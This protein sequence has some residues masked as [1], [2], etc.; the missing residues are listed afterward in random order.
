MINNISQ[1]ITVFLSTTALV[2]SLIMTALPASAKEKGGHQ[3]MVVDGRGQV[4]ASVRVSAQSNE[5]DEDEEQTGIGHEIDKAIK[6]A[7]KTLREAIREATKDFRESMR[8]ARKHL[9]EALK[10]AN[11]SISARVDAINDYREAI[12]ENI[13]N[14]KERL[15]QARQAFKDAI[16]D[17]FDGENQAPTANPQSVAVAEDSSVNITLTGSDPESSPLTYA[18]VTGPA[19][20]TLTGTAPALTYTPAANF[21]GS[22]SFTF[23]VNDGT[24]NSAT[25]TVSVTVVAV[26]DAPVALNQSTSTPTGTQKTITLSGTDV[27]MSAGTYTFTVLTQPANGVVAPVSGAATIVGSNLSADV[28]YTPNV[29]FNGSNSFT[30][31]LGDGTALSNTATVTVTVGP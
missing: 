24:Q 11:G 20:G 1:K 25:A 21:N 18:V 26:N 5:E 4:G 7:E 10:E 23:R 6:E 8:E 3:E 31:R 28:N 12:M 17:I 29:G 13:D 27:D 2:G 15:E 14:L 9:Q 22:D 16:D 30:F 19:H